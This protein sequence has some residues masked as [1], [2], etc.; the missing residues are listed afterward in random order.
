MWNSK[1]L[2]VTKNLAPSAVVWDWLATE[3]VAKY[4]IG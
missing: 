2:G 4:E 3:M 1:K